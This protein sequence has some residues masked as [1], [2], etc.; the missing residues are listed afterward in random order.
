MLT[1]LQV[2]KHILKYT[3]YFINGYFLTVCYVL[4]TCMHVCACE[5]VCDEEY[6]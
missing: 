2:K 6:G 5:C 3:F 1:V 4:S